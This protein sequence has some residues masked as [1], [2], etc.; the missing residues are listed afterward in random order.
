MVAHVA[1]CWCA[2]D[3]GGSAGHDH[4]RAPANTVVEIE[5]VCVVHANAAVGDKAAD[6]AWVI[7]AVNGVLPAA[8]SHG[9]CPHRIA[10]APA[11]N[12]IRQPRLVAPDVGGR[13]P[14]RVQLLTADHGRTGPLLADSADTDRIA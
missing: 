11:R 14:G 10:R 12:N 1:R 6:R 2:C 3:P 5:Y 13:R 9:G 7:G 8:E 4:S